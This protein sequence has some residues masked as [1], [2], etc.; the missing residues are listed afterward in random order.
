MDVLERLFHWHSKS[1]GKSA[2]NLFLRLAVGETLPNDRTDWIKSDHLPSFDVHQNSPVWGDR[3][4]HVRRNFHVLF[5]SNLL[6]TIAA[7]L[8]PSSLKTVLDRAGPLAKI[9]RTAGIVRS[10]RP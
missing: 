9:L 2:R 3:G 8:R 1:G 6:S 5:V 4:S 7:S 10:A